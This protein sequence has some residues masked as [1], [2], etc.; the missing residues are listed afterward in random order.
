MTPIHLLPGLE[1]GPH[2]LVA[3]LAVLTLGS[4]QLRADD[5][6]KKTEVTFAEPVEVPGAVLEPGHYVLKLLGS[7][8]NRNIVEIQ[9][10]DHVSM[11]MFTIP[12]ERSD[13]PDKTVLTFYEM[14]AGQP[15]ALHQWFYPGD[16]MG[17][18]F[19]YS[20]KRAKEIALATKSIRPS[21]PPPSPVSAEERPA[22]AAVKAPPPKVAVARVDSPAARTS[23]TAAPNALRKDDAVVLETASPLP[24]WT[25]FGVLMTAGAFGLRLWRMNWQAKVT[26]RG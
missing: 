14:P 11:V 26:M 16:R 24:A 19:V 7:P 21:A 3:W 25:L 17:R 6:D 1:R 22:N 8:S 18:E 2:L 13:P 10:E 4:P 9:N 15:R 20:T 12:S 5:W 23:E